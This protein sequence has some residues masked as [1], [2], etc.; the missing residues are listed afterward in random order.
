M[1]ISYVSYISFSSGN[2]SYYHNSTTTK[3]SLLPDYSVTLD[4][5]LVFVWFKYLFNTLI[6]C[7]SYGSYDNEFIKGLPSQN[8]TFHV[9][10]VK[11]TF[12]MRMKIH[13]TNSKEFFLHS[14]KV[15]TFKFTT[16]LKIYLN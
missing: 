4:S 15:F 9:G 1:E 13:R 11:I 16:H 14:F 12:A 5:L 7:F 8:K 10:P 2:Y 6:L 3:V